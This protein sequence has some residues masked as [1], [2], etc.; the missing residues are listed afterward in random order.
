M[1]PNNNRVNVTFPFKA[2]QRHTRLASLFV[3]WLMMRRLRKFVALTGL[4]RRWQRLVLR[5]YDLLACMSAAWPQ[6]IVDAGFRR[7]L[8]WFQGLAHDVI[9]LVF[10]VAERVTGSI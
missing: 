2:P 10:L 8:T 7:G 4:G 1:T 6:H 3:G 5:R 9:L